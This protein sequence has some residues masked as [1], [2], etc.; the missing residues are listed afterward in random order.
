M[1]SF[2]EILFGKKSKKA[3]KR[4]RIKRNKRKGKAAED[5]VKMELQLQGF[6]VERTGKGSDFRAKKRDPITGEVIDE[7]LV[8]VKSGE[9]KLSRLQKKTKKKKGKENYIVARRNPF[10]F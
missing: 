3:K 5:Q 4:E 10:I 1:L 6:Q 8:E 2:D 9:S 7:K